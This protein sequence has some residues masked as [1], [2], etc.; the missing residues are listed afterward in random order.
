MFIIAEFKLVLDSSSVR[1]NLILVFKERLI[2]Y[3]NRAFVTI[4]E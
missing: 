4:K 3:E 1:K 2:E